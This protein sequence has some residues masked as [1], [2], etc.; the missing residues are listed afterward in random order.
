MKYIKYILLF[1]TIAFVSFL[2]YGLFIIEEVRGYVKINSAINYGYY[3]YLQEKHSSEQNTY[4]VY[5][6]DIDVIILC[7]KNKSKYKEL[8]LQSF[9]EKYNSIFLSF[10]LPSGE[11]NYG[12]LPWKYDIVEEE[13]DTESVLEFTS[14][15]FQGLSLRNSIELNLA[16]GTPNKLET[17]FRNRNGNKELESVN[18]NLPIMIVH[19]NFWE[20]HILKS[21]LSELKKNTR[22]NI[23]LITDSSQKALKESTNKKE[24]LDIFNQT[25]KKIF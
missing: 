18:E 11:F 10:Q 16:T 5:C 4:V 17:Y 1:L 24:F 8:K 3:F 14:L 7:L 23:K 13:S 6:P 19:L 25:Y 15:F 9:L 2:S 20:R 22:K 12:I 21:K